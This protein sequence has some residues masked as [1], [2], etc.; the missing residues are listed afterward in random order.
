L[1]ANT[2]PRNP[3]RRIKRRTTNDKDTHLPRTHRRQLS[4]RRQIHRAPLGNAERHRRRQDPV[5]P[6]RPQALLTTPLTS[7]SSDSKTSRKSPTAA[8]TSS[9]AI[10]PSTPRSSGPSSASRLPSKPSTAVP[11]R[12]S[13]CTPL[14]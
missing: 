3:S 13:A 12:K 2:P 4:Q 8:P 5:F 10:N 7:P 6:K 11:A 14:A 9:T 1:P